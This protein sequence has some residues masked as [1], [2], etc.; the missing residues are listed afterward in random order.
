MLLGPKWV[1]SREGLWFKAFY[2]HLD[3]LPDDLEPE[4]V[5]HGRSPRPP[6]TPDRVE[7]LVWITMACGQCVNSG[8]RAPLKTLSIA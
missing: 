3:F 7:V 1:N 2:A 4:A 6:H 5:E 8:K